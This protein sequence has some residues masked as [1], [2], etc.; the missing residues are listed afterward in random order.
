MHRILKKSGALLFAG[1]LYLLLLVLVPPAWVAVM[2]APGFSGAYRAMRFFAKVLFFL[3]GIPV[4]AR[5]LEHL[6]PSRHCIVVSNH[7][8]YSDPA[9]LAAALPVH[10]SYVAKRELTHL[11]I[12]RLF[13]QRLRTVF[14][15]RFNSTKCTVDARYV[16]RAALQGRSLIFFPE[17]TF[18]DM[19]GLQAFRMGAF[20]AAVRADVPVVPV[21][22]RGSRT[23]LPGNTWLPRRSAVSVKVCPPIYP[24]GDDRDAAVKLRNAV[25]AQILRYCGEPDL[26]R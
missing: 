10:I 6:D 14:V 19:P 25:R 20:L 9:I 8:S 18:Y 15:E 13:L 3:G 4:T 24:R 21:A 1:Y 5:G 11:L 12:S 7:C 22:I 16:M 26:D 2:V 17:G 23:L